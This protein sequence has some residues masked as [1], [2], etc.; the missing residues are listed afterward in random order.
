MADELHTA[1]TFLYATLSA[2]VTLAALVP[3]G[4]H[5]SHAPLASDADQ[6]PDAVVVFSY[7]SGQDVMV[8]DGERIL[9]RPLYL[10]RAIAPGNAYPTLASARLDYLLQDS[11]AGGGGTGVVSCVREAPFRLAEVDGD[12]HWRHAG[13][14]YRLHVDPT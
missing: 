4:I 1:A 7:Q 5:D 10:V 8:T 11:G 12:S 14:L 2:D 3:G 9:V 6:E 13:G